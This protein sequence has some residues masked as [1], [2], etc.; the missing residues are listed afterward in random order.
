MKPHPLR[1][2][3]TIADACVEIHTSTMGGIGCTEERLPAARHYRSTQK[4]W[5]LSWLL[6]L[7]RAYVHV[8]SYVLST[9]AACDFQQCSF[10]SS[11]V[12]SASRA[13]RSFEPYFPKGRLA[14]TDCVWGDPTVKGAA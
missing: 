5:L 11:V 1:I 8:R 4:G 2:I 6:F 12:H 9:A 14:G 3:P 7:D 10:L 13:A